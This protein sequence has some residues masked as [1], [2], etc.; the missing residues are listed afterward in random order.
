MQGA[1][2]FIR[3]KINV[4]LPS[5]TTMHQFKKTSHATA[6]LVTSYI[7]AHDKKVAT[8]NMHEYRVLYIAPGVILYPEDE[9]SEL[10]WENAL[11]EI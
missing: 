2:T 1:K 8:M 6:G 7:H 9:P 4:K 3:K 10:R 5:K 11:V